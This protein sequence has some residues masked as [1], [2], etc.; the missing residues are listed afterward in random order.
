MVPEGVDP[1]L[2]KRLQRAIADAIIECCRRHPVS[3]VISVPFP[4]CADGLLS[5]LVAMAAEIEMFDD[6]A[7]VDALAQAAATRIG[8]GVRT[9]RTARRRGE[10]TM[11]TT[12]Q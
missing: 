10:P 2:A 7:Q 5:V 12:V 4:E 1:E 6:D 3:S 8:N 11:T 9:L